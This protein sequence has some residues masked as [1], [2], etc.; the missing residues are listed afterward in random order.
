MNIRYA[1]QSEFNDVVSFYYGLIDS[2]RGAEYRPRWEKDIYPA[3]QFI[4]D[5][6]ERNELYVAVIDG[7]II[8]AA[9][10]NHDCAEGYEKASW[11]IDAGGD[12]IAVIHILAVS[13]RYQNKG[14][15]KKMVSYIIETSKKNGM[16]AIRLDVLAANKPAHRLYISMGFI[17]I[18]TIKLFYEDTGLTEFSLYELVL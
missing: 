14:I 6:I 11:K 13:S 18:D 8:S 3:R 15:A 9:V 5:S 2:M 16:K 7:E 10:I 17:C 12:Q 1:K 4:Y